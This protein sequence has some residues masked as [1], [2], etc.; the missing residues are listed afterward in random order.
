MNL[1]KS[2]SL[3]FVTLCFTTENNQIEQKLYLSLKGQV[4]SLLELK[5]LRQEGRNRDFF[6][7]IYTLHAMTLRTFCY[8]NLKF[9]QN[10]FIK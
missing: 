6:T 5:C 4:T 7:T 3:T 1:S 9:F 8:R 2:V 10:V